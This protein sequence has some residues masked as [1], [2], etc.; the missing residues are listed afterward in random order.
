MWAIQIR[1][2]KITRVFCVC[3]QNDVIS[4]NWPIF[5]WWKCRK[6]C[7]LLTFE[8]MLT[9]FRTKYMTIAKCDERIGRFAAQ[10][11]LCWCQTRNTITNYRWRKTAYESVIDGEKRLSTDYLIK[12]D[13]N[14]EIINKFADFCEDQFIFIAFQTHNLYSHNGKKMLSKGYPL[15]HKKSRLSKI[16]EETKLYKVFHTNCGRKILP[17]RQ[18]EDILYI[19]REDSKEWINI[20]SSQI[21]YIL[22]WN[23][24][25]GIRCF[26]IKNNG[27]TSMIDIEKSLNEP[28]LFYS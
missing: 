17:I 10:L 6:I 21:S 11:P 22:L 15:V 4:R 9:F 27:N 20:I 7:A 19:S 1:C 23:S 28:L 3:G 26:F 12:I 16:S 13:L 8:L 14:V 5:D 25:L 18:T 2:F 24:F